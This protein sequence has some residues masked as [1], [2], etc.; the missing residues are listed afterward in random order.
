M[1]SGICALCRECARV[2]AQLVS[3]LRYSLSLAERAN[4]SPNEREQAPRPRLIR[5]IR[6][7]EVFNEHLFLGVDPKDVHKNEYENRC[8][9]YQPVD[10]ESAASP[11]ENR[12]YVSGVADE[13]VWAAFYDD[14]RLSRTQR[15]RVVTT[16]DAH[17]PN[18]E[19]EAQ[20]TDRHSDPGQQ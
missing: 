12:P 5:A 2:G 15:A 9:R 6:V 4:T 20:N 13:S 19:T 17:R 14:L 18:S 8:G 16:E 10:R 11:D 3:V 1:T 7:A